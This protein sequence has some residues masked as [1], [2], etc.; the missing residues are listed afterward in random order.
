[1]PKSAVADLKT[2][3][4]EIG[5]EVQT[6]AKENSKLARQITEIDIDNV[7]SCEQKKSEALSM[8]LRDVVGRTRVEEILDSVALSVSEAWL[9]VTKV[10]LI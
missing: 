7:M 8:I 6:K 9:G 5:K 2:V 10:K 1:M 4:L 3:A